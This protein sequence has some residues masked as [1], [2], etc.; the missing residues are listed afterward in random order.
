MYRQPSSAISN[1]LP[2]VLPIHRVPG[3]IGTVR[4]T[5]AIYSIR[6]ADRQVFPKCLLAVTNTFHVQASFQTE[7][8]AGLPYGGCSQ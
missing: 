6:A 1:R 8:H 4:L 7:A 5:H 2:H 3:L